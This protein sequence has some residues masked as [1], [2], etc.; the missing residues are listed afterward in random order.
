MHSALLSR[1]REYTVFFIVSVGKIA[2]LSP[3]VKQ[4]SKSPESSTS[5]FHSF[6]VC[7]APSR[8]TFMTRTLDF[9]YEFSARAITG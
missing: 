9:P 7:K 5:T 1:A 3:A 2:L 8:F 6:T 4:V